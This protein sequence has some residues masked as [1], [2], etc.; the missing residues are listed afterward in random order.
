MCARKK[1]AEEQYSKTGSKKA[2]S[3]SQLEGLKTFFNIAKEK[4]TSINEKEDRSLWAVFLASPVLKMYRIYLGGICTYS[5][6]ATVFWICTCN[7]SLMHKASKAVLIIKVKIPLSCKR[8]WY[9]ALTFRGKLKGWYTWKCI[10]GS[11]R[12]W[13]HGLVSAE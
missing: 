13:S 6:I 4:F 2:R 9:W 8:N 7:Y 1:W 12:L 3:W 5:A 11:L 10:T